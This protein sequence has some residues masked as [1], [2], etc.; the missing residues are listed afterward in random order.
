MAL[1]EASRDLQSHRV[2]SSVE[3]FTQNHKYQPRGCAKW[4][5]SLTPTSLG[6]ITMGIYTKFYG[7][8]N[9]SCDI[10]VWTKVDQPTDQHCHPQSDAASVAN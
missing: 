9:I 7:P 2:S 3:Y 8:S 5:D 6:F 10:A 4:K 1:P